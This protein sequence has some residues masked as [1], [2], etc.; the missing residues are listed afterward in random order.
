[1]A[2]K[3]GNL[4]VR[5][6]I[7]LLAAAVKQ[8]APPEPDGEADF[9]LIYDISKFHDVANTVFYAVEKLT[10][11]PEP[12]LYKKWRDERSI[13][14]HRYL[15]QQDEFDSI[16][17]LFAA[18]GIDYMPMKGFAISNLYPSPEYR[19]MSDLD[20]LLRRDDL[21]RAGSLI[22]GM[23]YTVETE[24]AIHHDEF[25]KPPFMLVELHHEMIGVNSRFYDYYTDILDR[26]K[27]VGEHGYALSDEDSYV[28]QIVHLNKHYEESGTGIRS[29][30]DVYLFNEK[31]GGSL[32]W[33][34]VD[35]ELEKLGLTEFN[36][37]ITAIGR[38]WIRDEDVES[39]SKEEKYLLSSGS[40]G[41]DAQKYLNRKGDLKTGRFLLT[42]FF[43]PVGRMKYE[44][45]VLRKCILLLPA[46]YVYRIFHGLIVHH[47]QIKDEIN[48]LKEDKEKKSGR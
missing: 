11:K 38:K 40:Y 10:N 2:E 20:F 39:F 14:F 17:K 43:P 22:K 24:G 18:E 28:F 1:M 45:S 34:Y 32:D 27:K 9:K 19:F 37:M 13:G 5:Y 33:E 8:T 26:A 4:N 44:Y 25:I 42:R 12:E 23:G 48:V 7:R 36:R 16:T 21:K 15:V 30:V 41:T 47:K 35:A 6:F 46:V 3:A 31:K 29:V